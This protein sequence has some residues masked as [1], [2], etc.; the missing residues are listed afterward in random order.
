V[1]PFLDTALKNYSSGMQLRLAFAVAAHLEPEILLIDEVLAVGDMEFQKK[2]LGKMEEVSKQQ[3]RTILFVSH[4]MNQL[5]SLCTRSLLM[6]KGEI[7]FSGDTAAAIKKYSDTFYT[8]GSY[9]WQNNDPGNDYSITKIFLK[10]KNGTARSPVKPSE[11][12]FLEISLTA[13]RSISN[14]LIAV[15]FTNHE[16]LPVFTTTNADWDLH[17]M[18][19]PAG[20]HL[21]HVPLPSNLLIP[22]RYYIIISWNIPN[23]EELDKVENEIQIEIEEDDYP[24][25]VLKDGR[26]GVINK[27][28]RWEKII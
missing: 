8:Q 27:I 6:E 12:F 1:E 25:Y 2:C 5:K 19:I 20:H 13:K 3:G 26:L 10:D 7:I 28:I 15:R 22:G 18:H 9:H 11:G 16:N 21:F 23:V 24:G 17:Y 4:N 14:S